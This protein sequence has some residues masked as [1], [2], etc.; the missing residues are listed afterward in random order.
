MGGDGAD[1]ES[2]RAATT[3]TPACGPGATGAVDACICPEAM[4]GAAGFGGAG[5]DIV[6]G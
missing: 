6:A 5:A 1:A 2:A 3:G 4:T